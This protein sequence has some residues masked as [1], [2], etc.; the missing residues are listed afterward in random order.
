MRRSTSTKT[1]AFSWR[2]RDLR[3]IYGRC[4]ELGKMGVSCPVV[5]MSSCIPISVGYRIGSF[6]IRQ[7]SIVLHRIFDNLTEVSIVRQTITI[8]KNEK[9]RTPPSKT[10]DTEANSKYTSIHCSEWEPGYASPV[11]YQAIRVTI[12]FKLSSWNALCARGASPLRADARR[13][14]VYARKK[15]SK[16]MTCS[17]CCRRICQRSTHKGDN[18][19]AAKGCRRGNR[20]Y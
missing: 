3:Q 8:R 13:C 9:G 15:C 20:R 18:Y 11:L 10:G 19:S 17:Y 1:F 16:Y 12:T 4:R 7:K 14:S 5:T 2:F 6:D